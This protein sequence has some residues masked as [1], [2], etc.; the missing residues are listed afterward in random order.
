MSTNG[1]EY[2]FYGHSW[3]LMGIRVKKRLQSGL[4]CFVLVVVVGDA[5]EIVLSLWW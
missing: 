2:I 1:H 5:E 4:C 3:V